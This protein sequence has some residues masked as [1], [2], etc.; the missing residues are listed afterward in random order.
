MLNMMSMS[1][2]RMRYM[3]RIFELKLILICVRMKYM[4]I[5]SRF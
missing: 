1:I 4:M 2:L 5:D 3:L